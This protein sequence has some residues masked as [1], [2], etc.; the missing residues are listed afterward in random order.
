MSQLLHDL[1]VIVISH[2][3]LTRS[4]C[5]QNATMFAYGQTGSGKTYTM[6][7]ASEP[8]NGDHEGCLTR[9]LSEVFQGVAL[10]RKQEEC[11]YE[12]FILSSHPQNMCS[13]CMLLFESEV[14]FCC[15]D[16]RYPLPSLRSIM[17]SFEIFSIRQLAAST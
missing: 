4:K 17:K 1:S 9:A 14:S 11:E 10:K 5:R 16:L 2:M 13:R 8:P 7:T 12:V 3:N 15:C 6:G